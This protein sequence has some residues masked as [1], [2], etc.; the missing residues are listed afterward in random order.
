MVRPQN[1]KNNKHGRTTGVPTSKFF[2]HRMKTEKTASPL[3]ADSLDALRG[4]TIAMMVLCG[5]ICMWVLPRWMAHCQEPPPDLGFHPEIYGITWV[6]L[7]FP[8]FLFSMGA[9]F[10]F[11]IG[12]KLDKG[13]NRLDILGS[14]VSRAA[15]LT[16]FAIFLQ[17]VYPWA[18]DCPTPE[19]KW[20]IGLAAF[21]VLFLC[22]TRFSFIKSKWVRVSVTAAGYA[23]ATW[24][25]FYSDSYKG[26]RYVFDSELTFRV[27][28]CVVLF[29][30]PQAFKLIKNAPVRRILTLVA[31]FEAIYQSCSVINASAL[32]NFL[33]ESNIIILVLANMALFGMIIYMVSWR[34]PRTRLAFLAIL[35]A[36]FLSAETPESWQSAV[37]NW[38]PLPWFYQMRYLKYLFVVMPGVYVGEWLREWLMDKNGVRT[39]APSAAGALSRWSVAVVALLGVGIIVCNLWGLFVRDLTG[40]LLLSVIVTSIIAVAARTSGS[41]SPILTRLTNAGAF[42]LFLGLAFEAYQGGIRKDDPTYSYYFV[43]SGLACYMITTLYIICDV[44]GKRTLMSPLTLAGKNPMIAYV[45]ASLFI[46]PVL[47]FYGL[48]DQHLDFWEST[49]YWAVGRGVLLTALSV[50]VAAFFSW[51]KWFWRT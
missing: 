2:I 43:T 35:F 11:S 49:W 6:D 29:I 47:N 13:V 37:A 33:Y 39:M 19:I 16:F 40:N 30:L 36:F 50:A 12:G 23:A 10:P 7:V 34:S 46:M 48:G 20:L 5:A 42:L 31:Y 1:K 44:Y 21:A 38:S 26:Y 14:I 27:I 24:L 4:L 17:H 22:F 41:L 15:K 45:A 8:F 18:S 3:R 28:V 9:A 25:M 32:P 51:I